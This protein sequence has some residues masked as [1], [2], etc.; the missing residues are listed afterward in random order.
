MT[1]L[2]EGIVRWCFESEE[3]KLA[4]REGGRWTRLWGWVFE[5]NKG[6]MRC[7]EKCRFV[8]EGVL[9][10]AVEKGGKTSDLY[11]FGLLKGEWEE[12]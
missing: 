2:L 4:G 1:E 9:R 8:Q 3:S 6:S 11:V 7:F 5:E 10:G 12:T